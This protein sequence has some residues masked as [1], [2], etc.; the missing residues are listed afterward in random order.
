LTKTVVVPPLGQPLQALAEQTGLQLTDVLGGEREKLLFDGLDKGS[1]QFFRP[2]I[3]WNIVKE[4]QTMTVWVEPS[5]TSGGAPRYGWS[6]SSSFGGT[7]GEGRLSVIPE[8]I[9][10]RFFYPWMDQLGVTNRVTW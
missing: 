1:I 5:G 2:G 4:P 9:L 3:P 8:P 6:R 7:S 10:E